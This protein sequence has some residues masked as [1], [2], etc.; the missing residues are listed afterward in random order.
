MSR[1]KLFVH[2]GTQ[3]KPLVFSI[4]TYEILPGNFLEFVDEKTGK[5]KRFH[6]SWCELEVFP[7]D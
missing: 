2:I 4:S 6:A 1:Y 5:R 7:D 3:H